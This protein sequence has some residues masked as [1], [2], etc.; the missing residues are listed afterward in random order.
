MRTLY[1]DCFSGISGDM[2]LGAL[3]DCGINIE[4]FKKELAKLNIGG[5]TLEFSRAAKNSIEGTDVDV[6]LHEHGHYEYEHAHDHDHHSHEHEAEHSH[7]HSHE[8]VHSH[9]NHSHDHGHSHTHEE[10]N[11]GHEHN[12]EFH[13]HEH[14]HDAYDHEHSHNGH[15]HSHNRNL[16]DIEKIIDDSTISPRA[17]QISKDIF[18]KLAV[19]EAKIHGKPVEEVHFHE[20]GAVDS[21][22]DIVGCAICIDML[23]IEAFAA[24]PVNTGMGFVKSQHGII[25]V[26]GP[27]ALELLKGV[28]IYSRDIKTELVTPTGAA[29]ISTLCTDFGPIPNMVVEKTGYGTGKKDLEIPNL[30][31]VIIGDVKKNSN[32]VMMECNIDDMNSEFY[33]YT[34]KKLFDAGALDVFLTNIIMKKGRPAVKLS[35]IAKEETVDKLSEIIFS[36]TSTIGLRKYSVEREVLERKIFKVDTKYGEIS[37]KAAYRKGVLSNFAPEYE[38]VKETALKSGIPV[39]EVYNEAVKESL[40]IIERNVF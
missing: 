31:R 1:F 35:V 29:I 3:I 11:H 19:A 20:V 25:P 13:T 6:I 14:A 21:I 17:K 33:E 5:Y 24:S 36:E 4:D 10:H 22:V 15:T 8:H 38:D 27:A 30:L 23:D 2:T 40:N 37:I 34:M 7:D 12:G 28:P 32:I 16:G 9:D 39:K 26:P 18:K